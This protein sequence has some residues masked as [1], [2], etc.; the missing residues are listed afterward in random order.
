MNLIFG[1]TTPGPMAA[2]D[3]NNPVEQRCPF[4]TARSLQ[5]RQNLLSIRGVTP[6]KGHR[7]PLLGSLPSEGVAGA[8]G[9]EPSQ[10]EPVLGGAEAPTQDVVERVEIPVSSVIIKKRRELAS[11]AGKV[12]ESRTVD[13]Q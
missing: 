3:L 2:D 10:D 5:A 6:L 1:L 12:I 8:R 7:E 13:D 9:V 11:E 4:M